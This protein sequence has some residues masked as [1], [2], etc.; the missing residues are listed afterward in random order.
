MDHRC[1]VAAWGLDH[2]ALPHLK[3]TLRPGLH[4]AE[5]FGHTRQTEL[6]VVVGADGPLVGPLALL[7]DLERRDPARSLL[8]AEQA[9][10]ITALCEELV[11]ELAP[12]AARV[13][14]AATVPDSRLCLAVF[15]SGLSTARKAAY[16][17]A[18]KP[19]RRAMLSRWGLPGSLREA[20]TTFERWLDRLSH[21]PPDS[22]GTF[23]MADLVAAGLLS[24][25][26]PRPWTPY[27][28]PDPLPAATAA[29]RA[30]Y[31]A[32]PA[33]LWAT[34][35]YATHRGVSMAENH[36]RRGADVL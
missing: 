17:L 1:E 24:F 20:E 26:V 3:R 8:P 13:W 34:R 11:G 25:F 9:G 36:E 32:H 16:R 14:Y 19:V 30:R 5:I 28:L 10:A 15:G 31:A 18:L 4:T 21:G 27:H 2:H 7:H 22:D 35:T 23:T 33:I 12:A 29:L 6:P